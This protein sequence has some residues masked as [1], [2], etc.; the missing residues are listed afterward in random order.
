M[1]ENNVFVTESNERIDTGLNAENDNFIK[2]LEAEG[3]KLKTI[4][5]EYT[6]PTRVIILENVSSYEVVS[7]AAGKLIKVRQFNKEEDG[8]KQDTKY[9]TTYGLFFVGPFDDKDKSKMSSGY[10]IT[11]GL[12]YED[13]ARQSYEQRLTDDKLRKEY[14]E[15]YPDTFGYYSFANSFNESFNTDSRTATIKKNVTI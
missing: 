7:G 12:T 15:K 4:V 2:E 14:S 3:I 5:L 6:T 10:I 8:W 1:A 13:I 11:N 9:Y